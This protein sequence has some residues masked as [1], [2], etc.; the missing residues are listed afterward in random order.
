ML[1]TIAVRCKPHRPWYPTK[2]HIVLRPLTSPPANAVPSIPMIESCPEPTCACIS[3]P[4]GL[5]ID[6]TS[7][8]A[9]V[10]FQ[11]DIHVVVSTGKSSW[12]SRIENETWP[13]LA[14]SLKSQI[15]PGGK[16]LSVCLIILG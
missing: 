11:Y 6:R 1:R 8:L 16:L 14:R 7:S 5:E 2:R 15:G 13:N 3:T 9:G 4:E 10:M 12:K